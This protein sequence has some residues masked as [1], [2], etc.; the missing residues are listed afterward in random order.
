MRAQ[1][2]DIALIPGTATCCAFLDITTHDDG[3]M[4]TVRISSDDPAAAPVIA[5][6]AGKT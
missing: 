1:A 3:E 2:L 6:F 4:V 5:L